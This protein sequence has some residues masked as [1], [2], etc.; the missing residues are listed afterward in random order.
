MPGLTDDDR[1]RLHRRAKVESQAKQSAALDEVGSKIQ[2]GEFTS[3]EDLKRA[4][5]ASPFIEPGFHDEVLFNFQQAQPVDRE[6]R[7]AL[8]DQLNDLHAGFKAGTLSMEQYR[9]GHD[10]LAQVVYSLGSRDGSGALRQRVHALDPA[11]WNGSNLAED[12]VSGRQRTVEKL[13]KLYEDNQAFGSVGEAENAKPAERAQ[14]AQD[15]FRRRERIEDTVNSWVQANPDA[16]VDAINEK[17]RA[18]YLNDFASQILAPPDKADVEAVESYLRQ[19]E[20]PAPAA[21]GPPGARND[22]PD[23][24]VGGN[25]EAVVKSFEAGGAP[26]GFYPEAYWDHGQWSIGY[27]TKSKQGETITKEEAAQRLTGEL[28][29]HRERVI[30]EAGRV[31]LTL[32]AHELDALTSFDFNTG[33]IDQLL[34]GGTRSKPEIASKMLLYRNA[35]GQ[36]LRGLERRRIAESTLF[37][38]GYTN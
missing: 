25:L 35:S 22:T 18:V 31:G 12:K 38:R 32:E 2:R 10:E 1:Q 37:R 24:A 29:K 9:A 14:Q 34:A 5:T 27:G 19:K 33:R 15:I 16:S 4:L 3:E 20:T 26:Q 21:D 6:T 7:F 30:A 13:A 28:S 23:K 36:P 17:F 8:T 11:A